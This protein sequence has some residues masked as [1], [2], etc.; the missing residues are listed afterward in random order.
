MYLANSFNSSDFDA[1]KF[2]IIL[3]YFRIIYSIVL[4]CNIEKIQDLNV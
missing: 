3:K 2:K 1:F 4:I